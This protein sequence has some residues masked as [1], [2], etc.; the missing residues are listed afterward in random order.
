MVPTPR[1]A[2][3]L[4]PAGSIARLFKQY[5]GK[6]AVAVKS[7]PSGLDIAAS[8][9]GNKF[10]LHVANLDYRKSIEA[11]FAIAGASV[12]G[13]RVFAIAPDDLRTYVDQDQ[14]EVFKPQES[15]LPMRPT[16]QWRFAPGSV[17]AIELSV[18]GV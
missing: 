4:M 18:D 6:Q 7:A 1:G 15:E 10:Y 12:S 13:G 3:Y 5:N 14:P 8:R 17:C 9:A 11:S 16:P 2:S